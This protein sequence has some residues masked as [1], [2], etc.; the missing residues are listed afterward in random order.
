MNEYIF[1][2]IRDNEDVCYYNGEGLY[3]LG[4]E[5]LINELCELMCPQIKTHELNEIV[6]HIKRRTYV[7]RSKFDTK[8]H[9]LN[10]RNGLLNIQ[11]R[12]LQPHTSEY[13]SMV[14]M[15]TE[16]R[17][18]GRQAYRQAGIYID[19]S[20]FSTYADTTEDRICLFRKFV[21]TKTRNGCCLL[22]E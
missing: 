12:E 21:S 11:T 13:L 7:D 10:L 22:G 18:A 4:G 6:G 14:Q 15:P 2:T 1:A 17:P 9:V 5:S 16:Y 20:I 19:S 3:I 8:I